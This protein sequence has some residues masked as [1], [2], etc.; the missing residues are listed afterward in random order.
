MSLLSKLFSS[1]IASPI[2]AIKELFDVLHTSKEEKLQAQAVLDKIAQHPAELQV[3]L[4]K[5]EASHRSVFV[6]GWRPFIGWICG[7][8][9]GFY[10]IPQYAIASW[11][12]AHQAL[13]TNSLPPF[14]ATGEGLFE[15][16][17]ALLGMAT[18]RT[19]DKIN[20]KSR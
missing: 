20:G 4:N 13:E 1:E 5:I 14:P 16:V 8:S 2:V 6:A 11:L 12:W 7:I 19:I 15:L 3:A 17:L 18:I 9:L 10:F